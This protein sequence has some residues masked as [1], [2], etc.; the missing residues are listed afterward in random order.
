MKKQYKKR[1]ISDEDRLKKNASIKDSLKAT[2][3]KRESQDVI[4][5]T[6]K[7]DKSKMNLAQSVGIKMIFVQGKWMKNF[8]LAES[9]KEN[10]EIDIFKYEFT[11][12]VIHKDKDMNDVVSKLDMG[13]Q[14]KQS[15]VQLIRNEIKALSVSKKVGNTVG[16]LK[17]VTDYTSIDL[18]QYGV[19]YK[20]SE[21]QNKN[22]GKLKIQGFK[23]EFRIHGMKQ[24]RK[25]GRNYEFANA[26]LIKDSVGDYFLAV[27]LYIDK[28]ENQ[29]Y[30]AKNIKVEKHSFDFGCSKTAT[31]DDGAVANCSVQEP[32]RLKF[33]QLPLEKHKK[34]SKRYNSIKLQ[35][36]KQYIYMSNKKTD[37][38]NKILHQMF[39]AQSVIV[40]DE[41][42][43]S[44]Q[45]NGHGR[46]VTHSC[47]GRIKRKLEADT[48]GRVVILNKW[49]PT[50]KLCTCCGNR[51][52]L[53]LSDRVFECGC[54]C[55]AER[56]QYAAQNMIWFY[57]HGIGIGKDNDISYE[58][59]TEMINAA[60]TADNQ[61]REILQENIAS[62]ESGTE[63]TLK[64][65]RNGSLNSEREAV[66]ASASR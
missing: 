43:A 33:L 48:S 36:N 3:E 54:G 40:Q 45:E 19:T 6:F 39:E 66:T 8:L 4:V 55:H 53:S 23:K 59:L 57:E 7:L 64:N 62:G 28:A 47:L 2:R 21:T 15:I 41:Q 14:I 60:I 34:H 27:T 22:L 61:E 58:E 18:K 38:A 32:E 30:K 31:R 49:L 37:N 12:T 42:I 44:W 1:N 29:A 5:L 9:K 50:T 20:I 51:L 63:S 52:E 25:L 10:S 46:A 65:A 26:K 17:F 35:I 56:D 16:E 11:D 24:L 13:S